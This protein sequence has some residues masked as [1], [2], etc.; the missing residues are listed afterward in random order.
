MASVETKLIISGDATGAKKAFREVGGTVDQVKGKVSSFV[1]AYKVALA[2]LAAGVAVGM[3]GMAVAIKAA[4]KAAMEQETAETK[5]K[6]ALLATGT[7][8]EKLNKS[9]L[10]YANELQEVTMY[11]DDATISAMGMI[12]QFGKLNDE[13]MKKL[14]PNVMDLSTALGIDLNAAAQ[15]VGKTLGGTTNMLARYGVQVDMSGTQ[16]E[17]LASLTDALT[18]KFGGQAALMRGTFSGALFGVKNAYGEIIEEL[19]NLIIKSD[20]SVP[21][22]KKLENAFLRLSSFIGRNRDAMRN[23]GITIGVLLT[24]TAG[25]LALGLALPPLIKGFGALK[26]AIMGVRAAMIAIPFAAI[27]VSIAAMTTAVYGLA[28]A[29]ITTQNEQAKATNKQITTGEIWDKRAKQL[30][31]L[32]KNM[33]GVKAATT[34]CWRQMQKWG[35]TGEQWNIKTIADVD[36]IITQFKKAGKAAKKVYA[37]RPKIQPPV[38]PAIATVTG[39][40]GIEKAGKAAKISKQ[41]VDTKKKEADRISE[42]DKKSEEE[43]DKA[44][45]KE[46]AWMKTAVKANETMNKKIADDEENRL[47]ISAAKWEGY[48][49]IIE[50]SMLQAYETARKSGESFFSAFGKALGKAIKQYILAEQI[51]IIA[52][53]VTELAKAFIMAPLTFGTTLAAAAPIIASSAAG[54]AALEALVPNMAQGGIVKARE[55][56]TIVRIGEAGRDEAIVPLGSSNY[57]SNTYNIY[58]SEKIDLALVTEA[59]LR[60]DPKAI[61]LSKAIT[62]RGN[63][64]AR[65]A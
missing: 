59:V 37:E 38:I 46:I 39:G 33:F 12:Q 43:H 40:A 6:G 19:G 49:N 51:K 36:K 2:S 23:L 13:Q 55:G 35:L 57:G 65:E 3:A 58:V 44:M 21:S 63:L 45:Q 62:R 8:T 10:T 56:G 26:T 60:G 4:T 34:A 11:G 24:G 1:A 15:L 31:K 27:T 5:L 17:K 7:Y 9:W 20:N 41:K 28:N 32:K 54:I 64:L 18:A 22:L 14:I 47:K 48:G 16:S 61:G 50:T 52:T 42:I 30:Q 29:W 25:I 53:Q